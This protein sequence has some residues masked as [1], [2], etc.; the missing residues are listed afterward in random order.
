MQASVTDA[1]APDLLDGLPTGDRRKAAGSSPWLA[2]R[3][4]S[5]LALLIT[6]TAGV[7]AVVPLVAVIPSV[8]ALALAAALMVLALGGAALLA[9]MQRL[10]DDTGDEH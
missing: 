1:A 4:P 9:V 3:T 7:L 5:G 10:L 6:T 2:L 8:G